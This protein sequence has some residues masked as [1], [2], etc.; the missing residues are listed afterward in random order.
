MLLVYF[1]VILVNF[2]TTLSFS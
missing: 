1:S 2:L